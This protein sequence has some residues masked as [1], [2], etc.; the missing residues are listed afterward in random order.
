VDEHIDVLADP[1]VEP[2]YQHH[3]A[4]EP[5]IQ[6]AVAVALQA[7]DDPRRFRQQ[8]AP[9]VAGRR[10]VCLPRYSRT[11]SLAGVTGLGGRAAVSSIISTSAMASE[12][13]HHCIGMKNRLCRR[14]R[15]TVWPVA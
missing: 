5:E 6:R 12:T 4:A 13:D 2:E 8:A 1:V 7:V 9:G 15:T 3:A 14:R 10:R 11:V